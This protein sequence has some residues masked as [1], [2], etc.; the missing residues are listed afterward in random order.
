[1]R[2]EMF[3]LSVTMC[4]SVN[5]KL[6]RK[7]FSCLLLFLINPFDQSAYGVRGLNC[8]FYVRQKRAKLPLMNSFRY[9]LIKYQVFQ[10]RLCNGQ[11][12]GLM[13]SCIVFEGRMEDNIVCKDVQ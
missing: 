12:I 6:R 9:R 5:L 11:I 2:M 1:M 7:T 13:L 10:I 3:Q 8:T 4:R